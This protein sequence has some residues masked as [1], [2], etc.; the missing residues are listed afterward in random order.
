ML[1]DVQHTGAK[2]GVLG[3][4]ATYRSYNEK[5]CG[6]PNVS[7]RRAGGSEGAPTVV[8]A[9]RGPVLSR[10]RT[11]HPWQRRARP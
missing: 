10:A 5:P 6:K 2:H 8:H 9:D 4:C 3:C 7:V 1:L 11:L